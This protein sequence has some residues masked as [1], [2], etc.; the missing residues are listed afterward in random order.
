MYDYCSSSSS[1]LFYT[2]LMKLVMELLMN[3]ETNVV[4][5]QRTEF[6][7][8]RSTMQALFPCKSLSLTY[9]MPIKHLRPNTHTLGVSRSKSLNHSRPKLLFT[10]LVDISH[11]KSIDCLLIDPSCKQL[12]R[13]HISDYPCLTLQS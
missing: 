1:C 5:I 13:W 11:C 10:W 4:M 8:V 9:C 7:K 12:Y 6:P 3:V 2:R